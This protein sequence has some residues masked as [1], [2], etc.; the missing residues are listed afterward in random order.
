MKDPAVLLSESLTAE[1]KGLLRELCEELIDQ[2]AERVTLE[3]LYR[4]FLPP[5]LHDPSLDLK[6][7]QSVIHRFHDGTLNKQRA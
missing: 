5:R 3:P 1:Q 6:K 4:V 7:A 2:G